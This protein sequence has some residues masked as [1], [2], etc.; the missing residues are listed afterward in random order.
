MPPVTN[1]H[2]FTTDGGNDNRIILP[3]RNII[4]SLDDILN[5]EMR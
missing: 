5:T 2:I 1:T 3:N 4:Y